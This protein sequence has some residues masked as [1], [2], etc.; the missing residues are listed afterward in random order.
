VPASVTDKGKHRATCNCERPGFVRAGIL[1]V[2]GAHQNG[3]QC[4]GHN[5]RNTSGPSSAN[6]A[7]IIGSQMPFRTECS[8]HTCSLWRPNPSN[9]VFSTCYLMTSTVPTTAATCFSY[10]IDVPGDSVHVQDHELKHL[11]SWN[12]FRQFMARPSLRSRAINGQVWTRKKMTEP[13]V[14]P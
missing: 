10:S 6:E 3:K 2:H 9:W 14:G 7:S 11:Q 12:F 4:H 5:R 13:Y 1:L 8:F